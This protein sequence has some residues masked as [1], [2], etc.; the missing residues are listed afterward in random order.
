MKT[1]NE[2][3]QEIAE[4]RG[5]IEAIVDL[6]TRENREITKAEAKIVDEISGKGSEPGQMQVL[7]ESLER[8]IKIEEQR[9]I[10]VAEKMGGMVMARANENGRTQL[11]NSRGEKCHILNKNQSVVSAIGD[12][13]I[14]FGLG[15]CV[16]AMICGT[17]HAPD[18]IRNVMKEND[19]TTGGFLVPGHLLGSTIDLARAKAAVLRA[20]ATTVMMEGPELTMARVIGDPTFQIHGEL[21]DIDLSDISFGAVTLNAVT[22]ATRIQASREL[23]EDAPNFAQIVTNI[24]V[25]SLATQ[26]DKY[27]LQGSGASFT[28]LIN[29]STISSTGSIG[30]IEWLDIGTAATAVRVQNQEPNS[31]VMYPTVHDSLQNALTGDGVNA[32]KGWLGKPPSLENVELYHTTNIPVGYIITGD[33]TQLAWGIRQGALIEATTTGGDAFKKHALEFKITTR[34]DFALMRASAFYRLTG[35]TA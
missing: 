17:R 24:L 2:I 10:R 6:A 9:K 14:E 4:L 34:L 22:V 21:A 31:S 12:G 20:G 35:V 29:D 27:C 1:S 8:Q 16:K 3:R 23:A 19:N 32:A 18:A 26:V 33:F 5:K 25:E 13:G 30:A 11:Q 15:E 7:T 28:G